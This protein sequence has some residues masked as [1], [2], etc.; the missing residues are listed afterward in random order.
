VIADF[1][2]IIIGGGL[3]G[4]SF[5]CCLSDTKLRIAIIESIA[6]S[7]AAQPSYD[8]KGLALSQA[9]RKVLDSAGIWSQISQNAC[10]IKHLHVSDKGHFGFVRMHA[11]EAGVAEFGHVVIARELGQAINNQIDKQQN[12]H[13]FCPATVLSIQQED[14]DITISARVNNE[15][16]VITSKLLVIADG[17]QST[18]RR[19]VGLSAPIKEYE[20]S[21]IVT[22]ITPEKNH[23]YTAYERFTSNGPIAML[24]L[25]DGRC[26]LVYTVPTVNLDSYLEMDDEEFIQNVERDFTKRLG[27]LSNPGK[28]SSYPLFLITPEKQFKHRVVLLGNAAHTIHPN[29]AQG[30]NLC[31]RDLAMLAEIITDNFLD[32]RDIGSSAL[33]HEY[34][35]ARQNDQQQVVRFTDELASFFYNDD[36]TKVVGRNITMSLIDLVPALKLELANRAMGVRGHQA[37]TIRYN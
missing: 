13:V 12:V 37:K 10:P 19:D 22:N 3:V 1:D 29:A 36:F 32:D 27:K 8:D 9:S 2:I 4:A 17:S 34:V 24:P 25:H 26:K 21:A 30:F 35:S 16:I 7:E 28:R 11:E 31:L 14:R 20:Q 6:P 5:A 23:A 15:E 18:N 33:L